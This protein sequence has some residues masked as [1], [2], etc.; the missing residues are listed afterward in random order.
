MRPG[1][2]P[3]TG[4]TV[5]TVAT[6]EP[7]EPGTLI[8]WCV[9]LNTSFNDGACTLDAHAD[10][11]FA[12]K[13]IA[14]EE[15]A[16]FLR[17]VLYGVTRFRGLIDAVVQSFYHNNASTALRSD[18]HLYTVFVYLHIIRLNELRFSGY[19]RLCLSQDAQK[20][21][22]LLGY[23]GDVSQLR[24]WCRDEWLKLYDH[25]WVEALLESLA[26]WQP[27]I[28]QL[29][30]TLEQRVFLKRKEEEL[31]AGSGEQDTADTADGTKA[32]KHTVP[33]P[34]KLHSPKQKAP[35]PPYVPPPPPKAKPVPKWRNGP[36]TEQVAVEANR[37]RIREEVG[38]RHARARAPELSTLRRPSNL[39]TVRAEVEAQREKE[40]QPWA[41][42]KP[43]PPRPQAAVRL[44]ATA[45]L[46]EDA[47]YKRRME[48]EAELLK[49][50]E[51]ELR[52]GAEFDAWRRKAL[53]GDEAA[54]RAAVARRREESK[55]SGR[56]ASEASEAI[57]S[58]ARV[59]GAADRA[60]AKQ[61]VDW[62][63]SAEARE[64]EAKAV[65][66]R[67][68][69]SEHSRTR[70]SREALAARNR[71]RAEARATERAANARR[72]ADERAAEAAVREDLIRQLRAMDRV[73]RPTSATRA[74]DPTA[75][76]G[77]GLLEEMSL[78]ELRAK[79][80]ATKQRAAQLE[81]DRRK[82]NRTA[83]SE[84]DAKMLAAADNISRIREANTAKAAARRAVNA[85]RAQ[86]EAEEREA[87]HARGTL[88]MAD[89]MATKRA[90]D[91]A[92]VERLA[93]EAKALRFERQRLAAVGDSVEETNFLELRAG[94]DR[95]ARQRQA[96]RK[97]EEATY[98][99]TKARLESVRNTYL[100]KE[101]R[102]AKA[103]IALYDTKVGA[104]TEAD[105]LAQ[106]AEAKRRRDLVIAEHKDAVRRQAKLDGT[107]GRTYERMRTQ[108]TLGASTRLASTGG[109]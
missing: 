85:A 105:R 65:R 91:A 101:R 16:T 69:A 100:S 106:M 40:L 76:P 36:T 102:A 93:A 109:V 71:A 20:M 98:E 88:A 34:F 52:D 89:R 31:E 46:R 12:R 41:T 32:L 38:A 44:N 80:A 23:I 3:G 7:M 90:Q 58:A 99:A 15:D 51:S 74:F 67:R 96:T 56:R 1:T 63:R 47:L 22:V 60:E 28:D 59:A 92:E 48:E 9:E 5:G 55:E 13:R 66:A 68:I 94:A 84:R 14:N 86:K 49:A 62:R 64:R 8:K 37:Q 72:V 70:E 10:E 78:A 35:P 39:D 45:V 77:H 108:G 97:A 11:F 29:V 75:S 104:L 79:L 61:R 19:R 18:V 53:E 42:V 25:T 6:G 43:V 30:A 83:R 87:S 17:Q 73:K 50:Y 107:M 82:A 27:D 81:E 26:A 95:A 2:R 103:K 33:Q 57:K 21:L 54:S 24:E 4:H